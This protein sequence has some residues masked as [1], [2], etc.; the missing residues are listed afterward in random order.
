MGS[1]GCTLGAET[2]AITGTLVCP[3]VG[4]LAGI[5]IE[6]IGEGICMGA[7]PSIITRNIL[8]ETDDPE[9]NTNSEDNTQKKREQIATIT[10]LFLLSTLR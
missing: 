10:V 4:T 6:S 3:G 5:V 2:G 1:R 8:K 7:L 9:P